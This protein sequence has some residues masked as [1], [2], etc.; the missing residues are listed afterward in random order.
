MTEKCVAALIIVG[1][2]ILRGQVQDAHTVYL[3][4]SLQNIGI[5]IR[6]ITIIPDEVINSQLKNSQALV[7]LKI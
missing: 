4:K 5:K 7:I 1:D 6:K 2:E 3:A